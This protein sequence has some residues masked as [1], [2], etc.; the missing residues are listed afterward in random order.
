MCR[1]HASN[2][3]KEGK[4]GEVRRKGIVVTFDVKERGRFKTS[5]GA[6]VGTQ[7][8]DAVSQ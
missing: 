1:L 8:G 4:E 7:S 5:I 3:A 2:E 6:N